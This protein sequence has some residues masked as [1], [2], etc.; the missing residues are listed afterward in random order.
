MLLRERNL[1]N[2]PVREP[3]YVICYLCGRRYG[4]K[5]ISIHEPNCLKK[6][7][8]EN[9]KLP[10]K[11]RRKPPVRPSA[12]DS[13]SSIGAYGREDL[14]AVNE[15]A[16]LSAQDQLIPCVNC[17]RT[18]MPDRLPVHQRSCKADNPARPVTTGKG[19]VDAK[20]ST[21]NYSLN[22]LHQSN[23]R[24]L[25]GASPNQDYEGAD[26]YFTSSS[27]NKSL[28]KK[29]QRQGTFTL[30]DPKLI[31]DN[32][33]E[34]SGYDDYHIG[35]Q[36]SRH[37]SKSSRGQRD[38]LKTP[39][40]AAA[41]FSETQQDSMDLVP[42]PNCGRNFASNRIQKHH[43]VCVKTQSKTR[44]VFDS[45]K[46]R[47]QGTEAAKHYRPWLKNKQQQH[48]PPKSNW[49]QQ[50]EDFIKSV[51]AARQV[52]KHMA[53]GG[54]ASDLPPPPPSINPDYVFCDYC[55][56]RFNPEVAERHIPKCRTTINRPRPPK[57]RAIDVHKM[58]T[59]NNGLVSGKTSSKKQH[60]L[61]KRQPST[62]NFS[63]AS[64]V[65]SSSGRLGMRNGPQE[66][67]NY[68]TNQ[69]NP[70]SYQRANIPDDFQLPKKSLRNKPGNSYMQ[71]TPPRVKQDI[72]RNSERV[73]LPSPNSQQFGAGGR[74]YQV[75]GMS[76]TNY[77]YNS[78]APS[79]GQDTSVN[80]Y[81][82]NALKGKYGNRMLMR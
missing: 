59:A 68:H 57:Q 78:I 81:S 46:Q 70:Y 49:R 36:N 45:G 69:Y 31:K 76:G 17:G 52:T 34:T 30:E 37:P 72:N 47:V 21:A 18:F 63:R 25:F 61:I 22:Q 55:Q 66:M 23:D 64:P 20:P 27:R 75:N 79:R 43:T 28:K 53:E 41:S 38:R 16:F 42:C 15:A 24:S 33:D 71:T 12:Y 14:D 77:K 5:S 10:K 67:E 40:N 44:K 4:T 35:N 13:I 62:Q 65:S 60:L 39:V 48:I 8:L 82:Y 54:K 58:K 19:R 56:R 11:L 26:D 51:R 50:H 32:Y 6:W 9:N 29:H 3:P 2:M 7:H 80:N 74:T 73:T 1:F